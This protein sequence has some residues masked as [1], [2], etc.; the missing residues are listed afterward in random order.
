M[1][2][3]M[4]NMDT[5]IVIM[6]AKLSKDIGNVRIEM[7]AAF[8]HLKGVVIDTFKTAEKELSGVK[9]RIFDIEERLNHDFPWSKP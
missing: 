5:R 8:N 4:E 1:E 3:R 9:V 6:E 2:A 7:R